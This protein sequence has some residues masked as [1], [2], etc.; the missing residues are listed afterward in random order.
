[1]TAAVERFVRADYDL[2]A[3]AILLCESD[4]TPEEVAEESPDE[5]SSARRGHR[6]SKVSRTRRSA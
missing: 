3:A 1:M 5:Q 4:G 2:N 6:G